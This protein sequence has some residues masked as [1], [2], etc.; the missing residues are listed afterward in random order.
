MNG[1]HQ[2]GNFGEKPGDLPGNLQS[3]QIGHLEIQQ[4]HVRRITLD[5]LQCFS[6]GSSL[7]AYLP[8]ALLLE[9]S[10][11]I[12]PDRRVIVYDKNSNQAVPLLDL[13]G[14]LVQPRS[15]TNGVNIVWS[16]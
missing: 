3:V 16:D 13:S 4:N 15:D 6:S 2:D 12:V 8:G 11:K 5:P 9:K 7:V 1:N 10:P 14:Q